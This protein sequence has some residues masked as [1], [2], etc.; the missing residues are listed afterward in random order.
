MTTVLGGLAGTQALVGFGANDT[1]L[2]TGGLID[3]AGSSSLAFSSAEGR[4]DH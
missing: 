3:I 4:Y 1:G 2:V